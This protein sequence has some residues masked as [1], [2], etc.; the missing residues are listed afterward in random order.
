MAVAA[1]CLTAFYRNEVR[2]PILSVRRGN[3]TEPT[4]GALTSGRGRVHF[5]AI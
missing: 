3:D 5:A 1:S 2:R 4:S